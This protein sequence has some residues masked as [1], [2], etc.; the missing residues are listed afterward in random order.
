MKRV[1]MNMEYCIGCK[2]CELACIT[3][4]SQSKD[5]IIAYT[6]ERAKGLMSFKK[7]FKEGA[8]CASIGCRHCDEP[9]CVT[10]CISGALTKDPVSGRTLFDADKC[11]GCFSCMMACPF[12]AIDRDASGKKISKCDRC[13][14]RDIPACVAACPNSVLLYEER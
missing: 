2:L 13:L 11:V 7:V 8:L 3:S 12:G 6:Q 1:Y 4:H 10:A 9:A 5:L 14:E